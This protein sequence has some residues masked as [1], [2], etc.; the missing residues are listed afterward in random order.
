MKSYDETI[1]NVF[2]RIGQYEKRKRERRKTVTRTIMSFACVCLI[3]LLGVGVW[4]NGKVPVDSTQSSH[5]TTVADDKNGLQIGTNTGEVI[6][7]EGEIFFNTITENFTFEYPDKNGIAVFMDDEIPM[8]KEEINEYFGVNVFPTCPD[9]FELT[10]QWLGIY[11]RNKGT[12]DVYF[13]TNKLQYTNV[14]NS[15]TIA[16]NFGTNC[17]RYLNEEFWSDM[18]DDFFGVKYE[19][20]KKS[21]I[22]GVEMLIVENARNQYYAEFTYKGVM[23]S[24]FSENATRNEFLLIISS[25]VS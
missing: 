8:T 10:P 21:Y 25:I 23:F 20:V 17:V 16:V 18:Y 14:D 13:D 4:R 3:M 9:G 19:D 1:N 22:D 2:D 15:K 24:V 11:K 12:G 7:G 6:F 5:S